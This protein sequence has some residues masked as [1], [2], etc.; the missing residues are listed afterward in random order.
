MNKLKKCKQC[1]RELPKNTDYFFKK[2]DTKDGFTNKCKQCTGQEFTKYLDLKDGE[3]FCKGCRR[4][5]PH[6]GDHFPKD[7]NLKT[8]L[9]NVCFE[10]KG[11]TFGERKPQSV[12]W[13]Q[14]ED[15]LLKKEYPDN[16]NIDIA[17]LFPNRTEK[18]IT[19]RASKLGI[20]KSEIEQEKRYERHSE[21][22]FQNSHWIGIPKSEQEKQ[23]H[24]KRMKRKWQEDYDEML[25]NV[26]YE[27]TSEHREYLSK[28]K[29]EAGA[30]KGENNPRAI[31]PLFGSENGRWLGGI[32]PLLFWLRNQLGEWKQESMKH[33]NY[34]CALSGESFEEIHHLTSFKQIVSETLDETGFKYTK[35]LEDYSDKELEILRA[36]IIKNN[37]KYGYG[38]CLTKEIHKTF[39]DLYGYGNNTPKQFEEFKQRYFNKEFNHLNKNKLLNI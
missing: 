2:K 34:A 29:S 37:N 21:F 5:L 25:A 6:D 11:K 1:E 31:N 23:Q 13:T 18:A 7:K 12:K 20:S 32:T 14:Q 9:R 19:D 15:D 3:M 38:V 10:C 4:I 35:S 8:G 36:A 24:S 26:Q 28:I 17:H 22:M 30:W 39:H 16:L 27:R 33:H